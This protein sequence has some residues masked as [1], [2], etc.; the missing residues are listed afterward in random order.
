M[1]GMDIHLAKHSILLH[2]SEVAS[3][4]TCFRRR[5]VLQTELHDS[6]QTQLHDCQ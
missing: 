3:C 5:P 6:M 4:I 2:S 1:P